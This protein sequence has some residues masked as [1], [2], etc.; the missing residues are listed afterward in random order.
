M[1]FYIEPGSSKTREVEEK[2]YVWLDTQAGSEKENCIHPR[3][4]LNHLY[5]AFLRFPLANHVLPDSES[6]FAYLRVLPLCT[7]IS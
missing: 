5:G 4:S 6:V 7:C 1:N 2:G 3:G